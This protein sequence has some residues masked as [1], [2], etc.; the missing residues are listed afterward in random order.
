M[1]FLE[2]FYYY[3]ISIRRVVTSSRVGKSFG[4]CFATASLEQRK[5]SQTWTEVSLFVSAESKFPRLAEASTIRPNGRQCSKACSTLSSIQF[6][7]ILPK[8]R[9]PKLHHPF[10]SYFTQASPSCCTHHPEPQ[11]PTHPLARSHLTHCFVRPTHPSSMLSLLPI[12][13]QEKRL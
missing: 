6:E 2:V 13:K 8:T 10:S 9:P 4:Q 7:S 3:A 5:T 12:I 1:F 11:S